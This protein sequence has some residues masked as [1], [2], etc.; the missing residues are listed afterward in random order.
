MDLNFGRT[1]IGTQCT[2]L[3]KGAEKELPEFY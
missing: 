1:S 2:S 3:G